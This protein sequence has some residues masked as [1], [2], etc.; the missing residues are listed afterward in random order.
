MAGGLIGHL[1]IVP[2][3]DVHGWT[4][5]TRRKCYNTH[6]ACILRNQFII[7]NDKNGFK[8]HLFVYSSEG[9]PVLFI[10]LINPSNL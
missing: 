6:I 7:R 8:F 2:T 4:V 5:T 9:V 10:I 1:T 3:P